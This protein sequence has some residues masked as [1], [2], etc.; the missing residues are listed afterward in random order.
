MA[1]VLTR[2]PITDAKVRRLA[3]AEELAELASLVVPIEELVE[4]NA[5]AI[6]LGSDRDKAMFLLFVDMWR[7]TNPG[8]TQQEARA[9]VRERLRVHL[10][11]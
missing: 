1:Y 5:N 3:S 11:K 7:E 4:R 9:A 10:T 8:M 2:D 6:E